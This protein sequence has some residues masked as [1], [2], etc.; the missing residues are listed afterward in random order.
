MKL[1]ALYKTPADPA[2]FDTAYFKTHLP[3]IQQVPGIQQTKITR[4]TRTVMGD[5]LYLMAEMF[6]ADETGLKAAMKSQEMAAAGANL[7]TFAKGLV[8][9]LYAKEE[10]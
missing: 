6:F 4:F 9:L 1:V 8:T 2:A 5:N 10:A 3:M 7:D